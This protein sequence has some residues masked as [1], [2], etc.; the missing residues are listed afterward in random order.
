M[1]D[2]NG[3][4]SVR[5]R[6]LEEGTKYLEGDLRDA[7]RHPL[8]TALVVHGSPD[9]ERILGEGPRLGGAIISAARAYGTFLAV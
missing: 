6:V 4:S 8:G 5:V 9:P 7:P 1:V 3:L 2:M